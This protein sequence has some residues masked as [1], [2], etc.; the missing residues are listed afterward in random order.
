MLVS[1]SI[2]F[3]SYFT[4]INVFFFGTIFGCFQ[5]STVLIVLVNLISKTCIT[6]TISRE[7]VIH[8]V[9]YTIILEITDRKQY[10]VQTLTRKLVL[11]YSEK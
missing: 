5:S 11:D 10:K 8:V 1:S 2:T 7:N 4:S 9:Y 3:Q 6:Q